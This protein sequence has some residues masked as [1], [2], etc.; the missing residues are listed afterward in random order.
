MKRPSCC[1]LGW[2]PFAFVS[3]PQISEFVVLAA[4][5]GHVSL[6]LRSRA[7][8]RPVIGC[9]GYDPQPITFPACGFFRFAGLAFRFGCAIALI[10]AGRKRLYL[11][12]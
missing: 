10:E 8:R 7:A 2:C 3:P 12:S 6:L 9:P 4:R 5:L 1:F 11:L